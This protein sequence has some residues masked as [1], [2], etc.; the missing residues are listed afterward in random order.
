MYEHL[1]KKLPIGNALP[2]DTPWN[3]LLIPSFLHNT[4]PNKA[5]EEFNSI[6]NLPTI[7]SSLSL[8]T[9][10]HTFACKWNHGRVWSNSIRMW[11]DDHLLFPHPSSLNVSS[12]RN[13]SALFWFWWIW[14]EIPFIY[15]T[16][17][18]LTYFKLPNFLS[19][20]YQWYT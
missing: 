18:Y 17:I 3:T 5:L 19:I 15:R 6:L 1:H 13:K 16:N 11:R 20:K 10:L 14:H 12:T 7:Y 2:K 9:N 4:Y 8:I